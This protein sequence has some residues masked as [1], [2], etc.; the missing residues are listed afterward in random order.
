MPSGSFH[1]DDPPPL[2]E[3]QQKYWDPLLDWARTAFDVDIQVSSSILFHS[4]PPETKN[5]FDGILAQ[6]DPWEM[7]GVFIPFHCVTSLFKLVDS[8]GTRNIYNQI[9]YN[10]IS[11][12]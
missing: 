7:A 6:L 10:R 3:M 5:K 9:I 4:Q 12:S 2:V 11:I 1:N 8:H